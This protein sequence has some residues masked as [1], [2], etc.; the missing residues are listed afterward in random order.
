MFCVRPVGRVSDLCGC[1]RAGMN[2]AKINALGA[3]PVLPYL[4]QLDWSPSDDRCLHPFFRQLSGAASGAPSLSL[5][6]FVLRSVQRV[7]G[8]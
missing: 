2:E 8:K 1:N 7:D 5:T 3:A 6:V 4:T